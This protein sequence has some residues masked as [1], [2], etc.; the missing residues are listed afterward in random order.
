MP[1][2]ARSLETSL[3]LSV[4]S[5]VLLTNNI[6]QLAGLCNRS[7]GIVKDIVYEENTSPSH[8]PK[9]IMVDF[10]SQ[11]TGATFSLITRQEGVGF[12]FIL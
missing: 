11:Y 12:L 9:F 4:G 10:G 3:F 5:S 1:E 2:L 8:L 6:C 7:T